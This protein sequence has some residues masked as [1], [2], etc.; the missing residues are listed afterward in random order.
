[1]WDPGKCSLSGGLSFA[2]VTLAKLSNMILKDF[3]YL[4]EYMGCW[5]LSQLKSKSEL[6]QVMAIINTSLKKYAGLNREEAKP[7][8]S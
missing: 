6:F 2:W 5:A 3:K 1:M 4:Y 7:R 8:L